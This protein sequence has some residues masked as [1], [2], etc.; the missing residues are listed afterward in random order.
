MPLPLGESLSSAGAVV[1]KAS[2]GL[3]SASQ[4]NITAN[5]DST[6]YA[7]G[8]DDQE[9]TLNT[10]NPTG[11]S[12]TFTLHSSKLEK[13]TLGGSPIAVNIDGADISTET[14]TSSNRDATIVLGSSNADLSNIDRP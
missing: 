4:I 12:T 5:K 7:D 1:T 14:V 6:I 13:L 10:S 3:N 8:V 11:D 9:I 2:N